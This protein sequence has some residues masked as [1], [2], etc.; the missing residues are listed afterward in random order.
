MHGATMFI[1]E[2]VPKQIGKYG[3]DTAFFCTN[4][5]MQFPL[6][7]ACI[8]AGAIYPSPCCPSPYHAFPA[9][10]GLKSFVHDPMTGS[11]IQEIYDAK[12]IQAVIGETRD[13]LAD[14][15]LSGRFATWPVPASMAVTATFTEYALK[16]MDGETGGK[17]DLEVL[18]QCFKD[19]SGR[20]ITF[21][22]WEDD[23]GVIDNILLFF[24]DYVIL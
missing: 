14:A 19:F 23:D 24:I 3:P 15:G 17:L 11:Y 4:C 10:L 18:G 6:I 9:V 16:W 5:G 12:V 22:P 7:S 1:L 20:D 13:I 2:D 8:E 21:T